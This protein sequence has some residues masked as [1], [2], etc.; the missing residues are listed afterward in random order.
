[1]FVGWIRKS[2]FESDLSE[3][4]KRCIVDRNLILN[5]AFY[6]QSLCFGAYKGNSL[7]ALISAYAYEKS[8]LIN[9]F[10]YL[11]DVSDEVKKRLIKILLNNLSEEKKPVLI[12]ASIKEK[13]MFAEV[14]F[15]SYAKFTKVL[16]GSNKAVFNFTNAMSKSISNENF[17]PTVKK[18]DKACFR[19][20]RSEYI[21]KSLFKTS[22]LL[23]STNHGFQHSYALNKNII[24]LSPWIASAGAY[25]DI[26]KMMRGVIYHRGLKKIVAFIPSTVEEITNLYRSYKFDFLN[27][28]E[29]MY[30]NKKPD[31]NLEMIYGF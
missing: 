2:S 19:D 31:I 11:E 5:T 17:L 8:V 16:Y 20:D 28:Y 27:E 18:I 24:K 25:D 15:E 1:M 22:S 23:L 7:K 14:G 26:E 30:K 3:F 6:N 13:K 4:E 12:M 29:L 21:S 9:S 10:Y